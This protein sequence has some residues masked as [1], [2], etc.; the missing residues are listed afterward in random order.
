[1]LASL[2]YTKKHFLTRDRVKIIW[3]H[4]RNN[5]EKMD[6]K[7]YYYNNSIKYITWYLQIHVGVEKGDNHHVEYIHHSAKFISNFF[8]TW[9]GRSLS[10]DKVMIPNI[11]NRR[12]RVVSTLN[13]KAQYIMLYVYINWNRSLF[14]SSIK[15]QLFFLLNC[16]NAR[17]KWVRRTGP[18]NKQEAK[19]H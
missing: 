7:I 11:E 10:N 17:K 4:N 13:V 12:K 16:S 19:H 9:I 15:N 5:A 1:M 6:R 2:Y 3:R 14:A 18:C 8:K